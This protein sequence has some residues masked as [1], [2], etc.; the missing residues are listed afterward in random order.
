MMATQQEIQSSNGQPTSTSCVRTLTS[1]IK[2][3]QFATLCDG[4][5]NRQPT[6]KREMFKS[7]LESWR[8]KYKVLYPTNP[9]PPPE[10]FFPLMRLLLPEAD[11]DR[12]IYGI[13]E[14]VLARLLIDEMGLNVSGDAAQM[15]IHWKKNKPRV[16]AINQ[17]TRLA[18]LKINQSID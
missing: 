8:K 7:F 9:Q 18:F 11:R 10:T 14:H 5:A 13:K 3:S 15:L 17:S 4:I 12:P 2:F 6:K 16:G 1:T